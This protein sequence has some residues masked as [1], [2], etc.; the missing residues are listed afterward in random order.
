MLI[1]SGNILLCTSFK[2]V[3]FVCLFVVFNMLGDPVNIK[4]FYKIC[5]KFDQSRRRWADVVQM[6]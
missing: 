4:H 1:T 6:L 3:R 5:T 2:Y